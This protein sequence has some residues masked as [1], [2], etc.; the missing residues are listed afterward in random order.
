MT[1]FEKRIPEDD[2]MIEDW[3]EPEDEYEDDDLDYQIDDSKEP[4]N[5]E[6][7][8][9]VAG[10]TLEEID[11]ISRYLFDTIAKNLSIPYEKLEDL[12]IEED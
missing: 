4:K 3:P 11:W 9:K 8:F 1:D 10:A 2:T 6:V 12:E 5:Y 7:S